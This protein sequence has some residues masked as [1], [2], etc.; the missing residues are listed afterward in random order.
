M[1][2]FLLK[3]IILSFISLQFSCSKE[4]NEVNPNDPVDLEVNVVVSEDFNGLVNISASARN[5]IRYELRSGNTPV[6]SNETGEFEIVYTMPGVYALEIRAYGQSGKFLRVNRTVSIGGKEVVPLARGYM[7]PFEYEGYN[8]T[9]SEE[10][11]GSSLDLSVWTFEIG[12]GCPNLCGWGNNELQYYTMENTSL[13][14]STLTITASNEQLKGFNYTSSR[15]KTQNKKT[16]KYGRIDVRALLPQGQGLW[17][18]IWMLGNN[19][20]TVGW[21]SCGEI[22]IMELIGGQGR[23]NE[24]HG[25]LHWSNNGRQFTGTG[26]KLDSGIFANSYHVFSIIWDESSIKWLV[27]DYQF[28]EITITPDHMDEF[29]EE[30]FLLLNIAVGGNW[31][32]NP[33]ATTVFDQIMKID[34]IRY[35]EEI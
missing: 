24:V 28:H 23:D 29:R 14:D 19:I 18:A 15:L 25:T 17:P 2:R 3:I 5:S 7:S 26:Y 6:E 22:D 30:F 16:F 20:E 31:P 13:G 11:N 21:P 27:D 4:G 9:W 12:N 8:M 10:F 34:Y 1:N 32:G 33:D 35:F